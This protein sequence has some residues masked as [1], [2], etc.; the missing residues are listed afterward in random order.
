MFPS[1]FTRL[2]QSSHSFASWSMK[3]LHGIAG[4]F[5]SPF[6]V[7]TPRLPGAGAAACQRIRQV[8][9]AFA[10]AEDCF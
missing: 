3:A 1:D 2:G 5:P 8:E 10:K 4:S 6:S 7:A 9:K